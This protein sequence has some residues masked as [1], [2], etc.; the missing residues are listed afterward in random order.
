MRKLLALTALLF[1]LTPLAQAQRLQ[2]FGGYS[3]V[4]FRP[5]G[6]PTN[7]NGWN[8][9]VTANMLKV[10]GVTADF[11]KTQR[12]FSDDF[13]TTLTTFL[14]GPEVKFPAR[15]S[16]FA[17]ALFGGARLPA[18]A[19]LTDFSWAIGGGIDINAKKYI[20]LRLIQADYLHTNFGLGESMGIPLGNSQD[21]LRI[22]IGLT[23][24]F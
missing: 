19:T 24:R 4:H 17:H 10:L 18:G 16:P 1:V 3:Y 2:V 22:S 12:G 23:L 8:I 9:S 11:S 20:G 15:V 13:G 14:F 7:F 21:N 6:T 5:T